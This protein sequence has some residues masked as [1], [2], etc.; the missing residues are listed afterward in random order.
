MLFAWHGADIFG[1]APEA[2]KSALARSQSRLEEDVGGD[3]DGWDSVYP[4]ANPEA[5]HLDS[6]LPTRECPFSLPLTS[7]PFRLLLRWQNSMVSHRA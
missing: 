3:E 1:A 6:D 5:N 7:P 2:K 4:G